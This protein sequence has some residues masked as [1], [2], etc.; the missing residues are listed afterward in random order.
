[1]QEVLQQIQKRQEKVILTDVYWL[2]EELASLFFRRKILWL[3][4]DHDLNYAIHQ[5]QANSVKD[6]L[7]VL[8]PRFHR[9]SRT[10]FYQMARKIKLA[11]I[12]PDFHPIKGILELQIF[13]GQLR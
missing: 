5:L 3:K 4:S 10:A 11:P 9:I 13:R 2:P 6:F 1:M 12:T 7:L 8:S